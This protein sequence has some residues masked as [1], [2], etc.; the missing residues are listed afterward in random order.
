ME[1]IGLKQSEFG[2]LNEGER[3]ER[4]ASEITWNEID[5]KKRYQEMN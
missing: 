4:N 1:E 5:I 2:E 3:R